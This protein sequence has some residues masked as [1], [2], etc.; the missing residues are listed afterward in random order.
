MRFSRLGDGDL[1]VE[2]VGL[3]RALIGHILVREDHDGIT[4]GRIVETEAYVPDDP[5][6]HA[7][8]G[9]RPRNRSMF[10]APFRA[11]I[12]QIYGMHLCFNV[13]SEV[14]GEGAGVL[15]RA[16][17]PLEGVDLMMR[18]RGCNAL[19]NL[20]RGPS[21]L[22]EAL[23]IDRSLDGV[24]LIHDRRIWIAAP[25]RPQPEVATSP[26]IGISRAASRELR[27]YDAGNP[28]VS[29]P[30]SRRLEGYTRGVVLE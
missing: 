7:Y 25:D 23:D 27:F 3:A 24:E 13:S 17:V 14:E 19:R 12:Y 18:R 30:K 26:R 1:P 6:S 5:A 29:G 9:R 8:R 4:A 11:Y 2:T 16:L 20:C 22:C 21:R 28:M 10:L 15:I